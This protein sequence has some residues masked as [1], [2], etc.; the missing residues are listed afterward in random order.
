LLGRAAPCEGRALATDRVDLG[1]L[2]VNAS[3]EVLVQLSGPSC[4]MVP[5]VTCLPAGRD[6]TPDA[7]NTTCPTVGPVTFPCSFAFIFRASTPGTKVEAIVCSGGGITFTTT[8]TAEVVEIPAVDGS[9]D[10]DG[11]ASVD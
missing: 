11:G 1:T 3:A 4:M 10:Y 7:A 5:Q 2:P 6:L 9:A 8:V